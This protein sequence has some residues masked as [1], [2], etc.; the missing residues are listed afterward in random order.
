MLALGALGCMPDALQFETGGDAV[1]AAEDVV[2]ADASGSD[3]ISAG[4]PRFV[5]K[6]QAAI[7]CTR[8]RTCPELATS[9]LISNSVPIDTA[10][11]S[12]CIDWLAGPLPANRVGVDRQAAVVACV[13]S[14]NG[15]AAAL[16]CL[17]TNAIGP[18]DP[19][20]ADASGAAYCTDDGGTAVVCNGVPGAVAVHCT[21]TSFGPGDRC[22]ALPGNGAICGHALADGGCP[23]ACNQGVLTSC[24]VPG[25]AST[26]DCASQGYECVAQTGASTCA[27]G[28][29]VV[30]CS[31]FD[32]SCFHGSVGVCDGSE[33][34][35]FDCS[36][37]FGTCVPTDG[38]TPRCTRPGETCTS[39]DPTMNQCVGTTISLCVGGE[40]TTLDCAAL[41]MACASSACR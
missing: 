41:G 11:Y 6:E 20:C 26:Y 40:A 23:S 9:I 8:A 37:A 10:N 12:A 30:P 34:S 21:S 28:S 13:A 16:A 2:V 5:T 14:A 4:G 27:T 32:V 35:V 1:D 3:R 17:S 22:V 36:A 19:L 33:L 31:A 29:D 25:I 38:G 18:S 7:V 39:D 24:D 15:C